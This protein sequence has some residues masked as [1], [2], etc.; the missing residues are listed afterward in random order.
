MS[1]TIKTIKSLFSSGP[2][3]MI[4]YV[5]S[6]C[7]S[8]CKTCFYWDYLNTPRKEL[9][10]EE[11]Q[12][13]SKSFNN[14]AYVSLTGGEPFLRRDIDEIIKAFYFNSNTVY[15]AIPT[16]ALLTEL[17]VKS[18]NSVLKDCPDIRLH[19]DL[20]VDG[21]G[22]LHDYI[23]GVKGNFEKM[24]KTHEELLKIREKYPDNLF[25]NIHTC[26]NGYN[27]DKIYDLIE[28]FEK[29]DINHHRIGIARLDSRFPEAL[30]DKEKY[31]EVI[32]HMESK[33]SK[34]KGIISKAFKAIHE[35]NAEVNVKTLEENK[36]QLPCI[37]G[38][39]MIVMGDE[40]DVYPCEILSKKL[41]NI[42]NFDYDV[43]KLLE[44][45][46]A[47]DIRNWIVDTNCFC[48]WGCAIQNNV[49]FNPSKT[50]P[51]IAAKMLV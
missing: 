45:E 13:I 9:T 47:K 14:L 39:K 25:I 12:K 50:L 1:R 30:A 33:N 4:L 38:K 27:Q 22:E 28:F 11:I 37:A 42:R 29:L 35:I 44:S 34:P 46:N 8:K 36:M 32:H 3:Y 5:T 6:K 15:F 2:S 40:G 20:S 49:I 51:R 16:N 41:G 17:M 26:F 23:R 43:N 21:V 48:T 7:N 24:L 19:I 10:L 31:K 18:I